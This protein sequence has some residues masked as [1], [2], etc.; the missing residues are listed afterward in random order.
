V[1]GTDA[2]ELVADIH[3]RMPV[4]LAPGDY[5]RWLGDEPD[6][7]ELMR[8]FP[9]S[10]IVCGQSRRGSTTPTCLSFE[11]GDFFGIASNLS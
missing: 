8:S 1:R 3:D 7:R 10:L 2:N 4:F 5:S 9:A 11:L 6:P